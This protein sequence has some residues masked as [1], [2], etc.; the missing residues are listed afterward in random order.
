MRRRCLVEGVRG[1]MEAGALK[2]VTAG[3]PKVA[4]RFAALDGP[5]EEAFLLG[6]QA[7]ADPTRLRMVRLL[8][9]REQCVCHLT[10][11]L[12]LSQASISHHVAVLK[13]AGL[14]EDR[15]DTRWTYYRL[16]S[17]AVSVLRSS[18][19]ELLDAIPT[20]PSSAACCDSLGNPEQ[21]PCT[22]RQ[23][24]FTPARIAQVEDPKEA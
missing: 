15:R 11:L 24:R 4:E 10:E 3:R 21:G 9:E 6:L 1:E 23:S 5:N 8:A 18:V 22:A 7:L 20:D 12:G 14:V 19:D 2:K 13:R 16:V 17:Q